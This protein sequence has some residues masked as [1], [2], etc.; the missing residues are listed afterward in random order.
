M[1]PVASVNPPENS[2]LSFAFA[3][4]RKRNRIRLRTCDSSAGP[5]KKGSSRSR[6]SPLNENGP[7]FL[8][9]S[10]NDF[11]MV[12]TFADVFSPSLAIAVFA[13]A[14][15]NSACCASFS[16][17][18]AAVCAVCAICDAWSAPL[19]AR[20]AASLA[21][22]PAVAARSFAAASFSTMAFSS[23]ICFCCAATVSCRAFHCS[24]VPPEVFFFVPG[25]CVWPFTPAQMTNDNNN[26]APN[27]LSLTSPPYFDELCS[28]TRPSRCSNPQ[29][30]HFGRFHESRCSLS[31]FQP[32]L[33]GRI[34]GDNCRD[35]LLSNR[36]P[37]LRQ[38]AAVLHFQYASD[39]LIAPADPAEIPAP[40]FDGSAF[41]FF[42]DHAVDFALRNAM[43][44]AR[45][46]HGLE[47]P[48]VDPLL[49]RGIADAQN[50][51]RFSRRQQPLQSAPLRVVQNISNGFARAIRFNAL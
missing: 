46:L 11:I 10:L 31:D 4:T 13:S 25:F 30:H 37:N 50:V 15:L 21:C 51:R 14:A 18:A 48:V 44:P 19:C 32:H 16:L 45:R 33:F 9:L 27:A 40:C 38:Q 29:N 6:I 7:T 26:N 20:C 23:S 22:S 8:I 49:Q 1:S 17:V 24:A 5:P 12:C 47:L 34:G 35:M 43:V 2:S 36:H 41:Q 39:Q 28:P 42:R 3:L